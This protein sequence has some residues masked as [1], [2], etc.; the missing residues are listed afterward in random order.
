MGH[1]QTQD[2]VK[3]Q[4]T[5]PHSPP[6]Q[7]RHKANR[8][9]ASTCAYCLRVRNANR[10]YITLQLQLQPSLACGRRLPEWSSFAYAVT[11]APHTH[12]HTL[13]HTRS[14]TCACFGR[15]IESISV[16]GT[17]SP[18]P[19]PAQLHAVRQTQAKQTTQRLLL[20]SCKSTRRRRFVIALIT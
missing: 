19:L 12:T 3:P 9:A 16:T 13:A 6:Q 11:R 20:H 5:P 1:A 17:L 18:L 10:F 8:S 14:A 15:T 4:R 7:R 2:D